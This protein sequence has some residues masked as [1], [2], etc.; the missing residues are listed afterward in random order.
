MTAAPAPSWYTLTFPS[1]VAAD[2]VTAL[3]RVFHG[4]AGPAPRSE[5][6]ILQA[7]GRGGQVEHQVR[8]PP[9]RSAALLSQ[10]TVA[11][12]GLLLRP[13][14]VELSNVQAAWRLW[15]SSS[16]RPLRVNDPLVVS[17]AILTALTAAR[18]NERLILQWL[19]GPPRRP[20]VVST[21]HTPVLSE[22]WSRAI[23]TAP[24]R[25]PGDLDSEA[26]RA[27]RLKQGEAGW[28]VV[29]RIAVHAASRDRDL[30]LMAGL[31]GALR[32]A[33]GPGAHLGVRPLRPRVV[34]ESRPPLRWGLALNIEELTALIAWPLGDGPHPMV[35][36]RRSRLLPAPRGVDREHQGGRVLALQPVTG[37]AIA[38]SAA[39]AVHHTYLVGPTG[40]GKSTT[41]LH[42]IVQDMAAGRTVV[43]I[44]PKGD[45]IHEV[46]ARIPERRL[47]DVV[48]LD[49]GD[50]SPVGLNPLAVQTSLAAPDLI[51][52]QLLTIFARLNADSWGPRLSEL[53]HTALL[54]LARTPGMS[55]AALPPLLTNDSFRRRVVSGQ[56]DPLGV[57]PIWAGFERLS[58]EARS[59]AV[60][61]V[62]NKVRMLTARPALRAVLGQ[63]APRFA[64]QELFSARRPIL[65]ANLN[66]GV[67]GPDSARLLGTILLNQ[68]WQTALARSAIAPERRH[69][70][71][72]V[73]DE[74]QDYAGLPG[75]LGD[76]L[77]QARSLGVGFAVAH[78]H[79]DQLSP[80]LRAGVLANARSRVV[81]Q[82]SAADAQVLTRGH[83]ELTPEDITG[84]DAYEV[85]VRLSVDAAVT[86]YFS[87]RTRPAPP[88]SADPDQVKAIS[89]RRYGVP[90]RD[91]DA[92]LTALITGR[93]GN[94][95]RPIGRVQ[96]PA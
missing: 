14:R 33:E 47:P 16:R 11:V 13:A 87:G 28:R 40:T 19:L 75:D 23:L 12:P 36:Q 79:L 83:R 62:L 73:I 45:L 26:R 37:K 72:V 15:S 59:Q 63:G 85:Y 82:A 43:V 50:S 27:L 41:L 76:M 2:G 29:G 21:R 53:L 3:L 77:A 51:A 61:S 9:R 67:I 31:L 20:A 86:P 52:D 78:Q 44:E 39:G 65:L 8:L 89:R 91:T 68:L 35:A 90:R 64:L 84:L 7:T 66:K 38:Q 94:G 60:A 54:T 69:L 95:G 71:S 25:S 30:A 5:R 88:V 17:Q 46:L 57:S 81:F 24:I 48:L 32:T 10:A 42:L 56:D 80:S 18:T 55:L 49:P 34:T 70:V 74:L 4:L 93:S 6:L 58:D 22:S 92:A 96:R 1:Q